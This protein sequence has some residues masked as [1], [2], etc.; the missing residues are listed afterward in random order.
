MKKRLLL[1]IH[2]SAS[3]KTIQAIERDGLGSKIRPLYSLK[4][5]WKRVGTIAAVLL[6]LAGTS[7]YYWSHQKDQKRTVVVKSK[8]VQQ[9][10]LPGKQGAILTLADG[11]R[12]VLDSLGNGIVTTQGNQQVV[13][14]NGKI[15]Y[16]GISGTVPEKLLYNTMSTPKGRQYQLVLPDGSKVWLNAASSITYPIT[17]TGSERRVNVTGEVYFE[18]AHVSSEGGA[19][20]VPFIVKINTP[21][22][23]EGEVEVL[24][25]HFNINAY[26]DGAAIKTTLLEGSVRLR[27]GS[28]S[29]LIKPGQQGIFSNSPSEKIGVNSNADLEQVM[30]WKEGLFNFEGADLKTVLLQLGRWYDLDIIFEGTIPKRTFGGEIPMNLNLSQAL[31]VLEKMEVKYRREENKL[32]VSP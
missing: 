1:D 30:A 23:N 3:V 14:S 8:K 7:V 16:K 21:S 24:G 10:I 32:I 18:V 15:L 25:T 29:L 2:E 28:G 20:K 13:L 4:F 12:V 22:G 17:F 11:S 19:G 6:L 31:L 26:D 5:Y 9:D 27:K